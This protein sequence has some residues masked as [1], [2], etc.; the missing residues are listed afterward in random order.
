MPSFFQKQPCKSS[1]QK[2]LQAGHSLQEIIGFPQE[3]MQRFYSAA[4][5]LFQTGKE[6]EAADAFFFLAT[7][8]PAVHAYWL[9]LGMADQC[10]H[11]Y[12]E[13][14]S[15]YAMAS[16]L[17]VEN[18]LSYYHSAICY[19]ALHDE[20]NMRKSLEL[21]LEYAQGLPEH[22]A[23]RANVQLLLKLL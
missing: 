1:L 11:Q 16:L 2:A 13:A 6:S 10:R 8:N 3:L 5:N 20:E 19:H 23:V 15:A 7:L 21:A 9:A 12:E 22:E 4:Y 18:P 14:L 17:E